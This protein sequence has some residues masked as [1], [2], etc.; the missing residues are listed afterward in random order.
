MGGQMYSGPLQLNCSNGTGVPS[1]VHGTKGE[2]H[3]HLGHVLEIKISSYAVLEKVFSC[4]QL[5]KN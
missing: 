3:G 4:T 5:A 2:N 1:K